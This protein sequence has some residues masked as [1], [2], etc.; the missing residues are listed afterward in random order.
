MGEVAEISEE[1]ESSW[2]A[3]LAAVRAER[4]ARRLKF[5]VWVCKRGLR[6]EIYSR[7]GKKQ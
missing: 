5:M 3:A 7:E 6:C 2:G 4:T 1:I